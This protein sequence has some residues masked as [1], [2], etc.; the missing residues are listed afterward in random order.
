[1]AAPGVRSARLVA[2]VLALASACD[3]RPPTPTEPA[4]LVIVSVAIAGTGRGSVTSVP[5]GLTCEAA[6][7][8]ALFPRA[9]QVTLYAAAAPGSRF[10]GWSGACTGTA[11]AC[12]LHLGADVAVTAAFD[13][14]Q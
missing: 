6:S 7:C 2:L 10:A 12:P 13:L 9:W 5:S 11:S 1:M 3:E 8:A 4:G 14:A